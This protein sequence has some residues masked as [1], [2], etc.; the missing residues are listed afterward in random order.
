MRP[1]IFPNTFVTF[2]FCYDTTK[3]ILDKKPW[4]GKLAVNT[5][6]TSEDRHD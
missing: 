6:I 5:I 1:Q 2:L 4:G 3:N